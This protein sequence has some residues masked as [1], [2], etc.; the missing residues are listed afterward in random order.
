MLEDIERY[1]G[2]MRD[3]KR[4]SQHTITAYSHD[5]TTLHTYLMQSRETTTEGEIQS[6]LITR[7]DLR[8]FVMYLSEKGLTPSSINRYIATI[9]S[10]F[11]YL[12]RSGLVTTNP[13]QLLSAL[14]CAKSLPRYL[15]EQ[16]TQ[17][18]LEE[19]VAP[20]PP[21][22]ITAEDYRA[23]LEHTI[24]VVLYATGMRR[25]ELAQITQ[26]TLDLG[27]SQVHILG[28]GAKPRIIPLASAAQ[29]V[30]E[31]LMKIQKELGIICKTEKKYLFLSKDSQPLTPYQIYYIIKKWFKRLG[32]SSQMTPH[33]LRH[34]F[35]THLMNQD[36][37]LRVVQ[38]LLGHSSLSVT[39]RYTH[40][41]IEDLKREYH[42][43]HPRA[44][45]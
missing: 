40:T 6:S 9:R 12:L 44:K 19:S 2:Y 35:A 28:K 18:L 20:T 15:G 22:E 7:N 11:K 30:I 14:K 39:Q 8:S 29:E 21:K 41:S 34:S 10:F 45:K 17:T 5:L 27:Q 32:I 23:Q 16:Q 4:S 1:I 42:K 43:A 33:S 3:Q 26:S 36:V 13:A 31:N 24:I 25:G 37:S 38:E